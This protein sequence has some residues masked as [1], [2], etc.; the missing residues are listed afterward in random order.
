MS[1]SNSKNKKIIVVLSISAILIVLL[2]FGIYKAIVSQKATIYVFNNTYKAGSTL[3]SSMLIPMQVDKNIV[4]TGK[5]SDIGTQFI[6]SKTFEDVIKSG[7][8]LRVDVTANTFLTSTILTNQ[9]GNEIE[10]TMKSTAIAVTV[11]VDDVT[12]VTNE[13]G[14][15]SYVNI[16][17]IFGGS[18][19][20]YESLRVLAATKD[21]SGNL[22]SVTIE[23]NYEQ[24]QMITNAS[25]GG[26]IHL[27]L[28]NSNGYQRSGGDNSG[29]SI[30]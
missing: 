27:G 25:N 3:T 15:G 30:N 12:G 14:V 17:C 20:I 28:I 1:N 23:C 13:L 22:I 21:T 11:D 29:A 18:E 10:N 6:T 26:Y 2:C 7:D 9:G 19:T 5:S 16:S 24:F 8:T 4:I